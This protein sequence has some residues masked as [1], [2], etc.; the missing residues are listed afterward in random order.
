YT[1]TVSNVGQGPTFG[2]VT[3]VE[4]LPLG[5]TATDMSGTGWTCGIA[6]FAC[7][8]SDALPAGASYPAITVT[9][10]VSANAP[11]SV[12][13][14]VAVSGGGERNTANDTANDVTPIVQGADLTITKTH[15]GTFAQGQTGAVYTITVTNAGQTSTSGAA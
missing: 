8:R 14:S 9:V 11:V 13:N 7:T 2:L 5:L 15:A 1:V 3:V 10:N 12:T 4:S 6:T